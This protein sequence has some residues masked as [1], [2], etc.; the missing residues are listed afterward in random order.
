MKI[1]WFDRII[2]FLIAAFMLACA[3]LFAYVTLFPQ[4]AANASEVAGRIRYLGPSGVDGV[5]TAIFI[6]VGAAL[7]IL[8]V[9]VFFLSFANPAKKTPVRRSVMVRNGENGT[10][11]ITLE[12]ID[13]LVQKSARGFSE[14]K[15]C[16]SKVIATDFGDL[17]I[18]LRLH[19]MPDTDIPELTSRVQG[20]IKSYVETLSGITVREVK[21]IVESTGIAPQ[22]RVV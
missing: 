2:L 1:R 16:L 11:E 7:L 18:G 8:A 6:G 19:L 13:T 5:T 3:A 4:G 17:V 10:V 9:Y 12:A 22:S 14:I 15:D 21:V 20:E